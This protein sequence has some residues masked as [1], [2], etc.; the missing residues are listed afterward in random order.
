MPTSAAITAFRTA[1]AVLSPFVTIS[2]TGLGPRV[3]PSTK[4]SGWSLATAITSSRAALPCEVPFFAACITANATFFIY[5]TPNPSFSWCCPA[6]PPSSASRWLPRCWDY[7]LIH[8]L[9]NCFLAIF[10]GLV[11][12]ESETVVTVF[13][14]LHGQGIKSA[15]LLKLVGELSLKVFLICLLLLIPL[16]FHLDWSQIICVSPVASPWI[17]ICLC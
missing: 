1:P 15:I 5:L 16:L 6:S 11:L 9:P 10:S 17:S 2:I 13:A 12:D 4:A 7:I 3:W 14:L 8:I